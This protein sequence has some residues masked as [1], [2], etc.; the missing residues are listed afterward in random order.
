MADSKK[1]KI[2]KTDKILKKLSQNFQRLILGLVEFIDVKDIDVAVSVRLSDI[3]SKTDEKCIF[4]VF[5]LF[6]SL[7]RTASQPYRLSHINALQ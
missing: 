5:R 3:S 4:F 7:L 2:F 6:L 1:T